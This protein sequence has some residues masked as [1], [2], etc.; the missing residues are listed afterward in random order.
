ML[1]AALSIIQEEHRS[2][3]AVVQGLRYIVRESLAKSTLPDFSVLR[4]MV[5]YLDEFPE[6]LHHPKEDSYL[7]ARLRVRTHEAD[8]VID[9]LEQHHAESGL[10]VRDL[11]RAL[12]R[13]EGGAVDGLEDFSEAV[14]AFAE[15]TLDHIAREEQTLIPLARKY[16]S[17]ADWVEIGEAFGNNGDPRFDAAADSECRELF[18]RILRLAPPP[19]GAGPIRS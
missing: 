4:A 12:D 1:N 13:L 6:K 18:S 10:R 3:G 8:S 2:L 17:P 11:E 16:L 5:F 14:A 9:E 7:F 15:A 19:I